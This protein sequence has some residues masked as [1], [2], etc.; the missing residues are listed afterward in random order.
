MSATRQTAWTQEEFFAWAEAQEERYEFDG[1]A[2]EAMGG[3]TAGHSLLHVN[4]I[5][6]LGRRL[7]TPCIVLGADAGVATLGH[8]VRYPDALITCSPIDLSARTISG[9]VVVFE[10]LSPTSGRMDRLV[11]VREYAGVPTILRY[12]IVEYAFAGLTVLSRAHGTEGW[13]SEALGEGSSLSMP[14]VGVVLP[15][16]EIYDG[17]FETSRT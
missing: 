17:L 1:F 11:K 13:M 16:A 5:K 9:V 4:I 7:R 3:G 6:A 10:V 12:V 2:P 15:L 8:A 14:E